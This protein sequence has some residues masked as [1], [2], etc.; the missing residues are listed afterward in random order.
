MKIVRV[1]K[2]EICGIKTRTKNADETSGSGKIPA[3][4]DKFLKENY[5]DFDEIYAVYYGYESDFSG[6]YSLLIGTKSPPRGNYEKKVVGGGKYAV[7]SADGADSQTTRD[8]WVQIWKFFESS[9]IKRAYTMDF[10]RYLGGKVEI[11][12]SVE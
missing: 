11:Y 10:E 5:N 7:F 8:L 2:F 9:D 1:D 6:E 12:I 3:L 4:W